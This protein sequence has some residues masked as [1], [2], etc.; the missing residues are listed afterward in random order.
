MD[1]ERNGFSACIK[2]LFLSIHEWLNASYTIEMYDKC[3]Y[4][5]CDGMVDDTRP[6]YIKPIRI[7]RYK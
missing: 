6:L 4:A 1:F 7:D 3:A 2:G 5:Y